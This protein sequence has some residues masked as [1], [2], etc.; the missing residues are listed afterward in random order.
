LSS[1]EKE[2]FRS[3]NE[4]KEAILDILLKKLQ[5]KD[6]IKSRR[7]AAIA[8]GLFIDKRANKALNT[9]LN[10]NIKTVRFHVAAAL[11]YL[12]ENI[13]NIIKV[14]LQHKDE[15]VKQRANELM[16]NIGEIKR[17]AR[18]ISVKKR[19]RAIENTLEEEQKEECTNRLL[20]FSQKI[21]KV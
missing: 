15:E 13:P 17:R 3:I 6:S 7:D 21:F 19:L 16:E 10:D 9:A 5:D 4:F 14:N 18:T 20:T 11:E 2:E 1:I 12:G 8:L